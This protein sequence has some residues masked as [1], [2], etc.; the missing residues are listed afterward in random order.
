MKLALSKSKSISWGPLPV[1]AVHTVCWQTTS[2]HNGF[3][4]KLGDGPLHADVG[5]CGIFLLSG[6][7]VAVLQA[8]LE[9]EA[10]AQ[11]FLG[12]RSLFSEERQALGEL[13]FKI[14]KSG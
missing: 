6:S 4:Y 11:R 8:V 14:S 10:C 9:G 5:I 12:L 1:W 13:P 3:L 7:D 2:F